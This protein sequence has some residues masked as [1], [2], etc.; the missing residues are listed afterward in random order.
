MADDDTRVDE[1]EVTLAATRDEQSGPFASGAMPT[2]LGRF[3]ILHPL[4]EGGMGVV[5]AAYDEK[6]DRKI[7]I[8]LLRTRGGEPARLRL[9]REAQALARLSHPNVVQ[10][11]EIAEIVHQGVEQAYLVMEFV[12]GVTLG[13]WLATPRTRQEILA[14]FIAAGRGLAEAHA[15]GLVHRDFKPDNVMIRADGRVL[16]MDFGLAFADESSDAPELGEP[17]LSKLSQ[18]L[19]A[20]GAMMGTPAYMAPEQFLG[21]ATDAQTDQFG[22][23]VALWEALHG[24]RPFAGKDVAALSLAVTSGEISRPERRG[25]R[26]EVPSWLREILERGLARKP[27]DRWPSLASLLDALARDPTRSRRIA[28]ASLVAMATL[29]AAVVG[30]R[31]MAERERAERVAAC[32]AEGRAIEADWNDAIRSELERDFVATGLEFADEAWQSTQH[33]LDDYTRDWTELRTRVCV[34]TRVEQTRSEDSYEQVAACLDGRRA[35]LAGLSIAWKHA[36]RQTIVRATSAAATLLPASTCT[37]AAALALQIRPPEGS[38]EQVQRL[39][40]ELEQ[41]GALHI[42]AKY[43]QALVRYQAVLVEAEALGWRP[44]IAEARYAVGTAQNDAGQP[45][46]ALLSL[47]RGAVDAVAGGHDLVGLDTVTA[48][49]DVV[50]GRL[51][52]HDEALAWGELGQAMV[53]RLDLEGTLY[54]ATSLSALGNIRTIVGDFDIAIDLERRALA[55][56]EAVLGPDHPEVANSLDNLAGSEVAKGDFDQA[57]EHYRRA[58]AI[59]ESALGVDALEVAYTL[60]GM[61]AVYMQRGDLEGALATFERTRTILERLLGP[62]HVE[63]APSY[64]NLGVIRWQQGRLDEALASFR[65]AQELQEHVLGSEHPRVAAAIDNIG[66]V[67][68]SQ[69]AYEEALATHRRALAIREKT[70]GPDHADVAASLNNLGTVLAALGRDD[71]ALEHFERAKAI[72][73]LSLEPGHPYITSATINIADIALR[74]GELAISLPMHEQALAEFERSL[75]PDHVHLGYPLVG[76]GRARLGLGELALAHAAAQRAIDVRTGAAPP[77]ELADARFLLAEVLLAEG[78]PTR[79][80]ELALAAREDYRGLGKG[81]ETELATVD[82][83]L[84]AH[85]AE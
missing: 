58:L 85:P 40:V 74:R 51:A 2:R 79:A 43:D 33:W 29:L 76:I 62:D 1:G 38:R 23:C 9:I 36:D 83:W 44:L 30:A 45:E 41:A 78:E 25:E 42:A 52:R 64:N 35:I 15:A 80:R 67:L 59:R 13:E 70:L 10:I 24:Q 57:L 46:A 61:G 81:R 66:N 14:T 48:M 7:A 6:L 71:E 17:E 26:D 22:F 47:R 16:V 27:A 4:G 53:E 12:D 77:N 39:R 72:W 8:K 20:T 68:V 54:E 49:V 34:E 56:R 5:Y 84:A 37:D 21:Q 69:G 28:F 65:R 55:I 31:V 50:G 75:G 11:Y 82:A 63:L 32:E 18:H 19:T 60:N 3:P 73:A